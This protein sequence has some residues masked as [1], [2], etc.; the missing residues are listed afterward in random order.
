VAVFKELDFR[1][2]RETV[3]AKIDG[4]NNNLQ[5]LANVSTAIVR[6]VRKCLEVDGTRTFL[7][8]YVTSLVN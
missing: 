8:I 4:I 2:L 3:V 6:R 7:V 1:E 5:M